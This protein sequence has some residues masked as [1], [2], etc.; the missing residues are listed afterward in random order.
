MSTTEV[1]A[2][3][4]NGDVTIYGN[5]HNSFGGGIYIW[6]KLAEKYHVKM[7]VLD[8][9]PI[10]DRAG[11]LEEADNWVLIS[12]FDHCI[13]SKEH[14]PTLIQYLKT[15]IQAYR[16]STLVE[17]IE[18]LERALNDSEVEGVAFNQTSV[19]A[20]M[21]EVKLPEKDIVDSETRPYNIGR[22]EKHWWLTPETILEMRE[23]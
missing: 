6:A 14:L 3:R 7:N 17:E 16:S 18:I 21:W 9:K 13:V 20:D 19:V 4:K 2:V 12:T 22:D 5:A 8:F 23:Q 11:F 15:F 10:W 1:Y